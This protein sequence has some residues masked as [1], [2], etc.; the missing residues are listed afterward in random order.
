MAGVRVLVVEA[1]PDV[2]GA[3]LVAL[4]LN[5]ARVTGAASAAEALE[6]LAGEH[7]DVLVTAITPGEGEEGLA[8]IRRV[9]SLAPERGGRVPAAALTDDAA[10]DE[11]G[12]L[13]GA[14]YQL[15]LT[16]P[17]DASAL[18]A[19]VAKLAAQRLEGNAVA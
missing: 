11:A 10:T 14:G 8:F 3:L 18:V 17:V 7:P 6:R 1:D 12:H 13:L 15:H 2:R 19:A 9:R 16:K 5:G 4:Q